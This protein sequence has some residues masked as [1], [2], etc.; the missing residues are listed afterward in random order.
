V[1]GAFKTAATIAAILPMATNIVGAPNLAKQLAS[2]PQLAQ[3]LGNQG[4]VMAGAGVQRQIDD[5]VRLVQ[6]YG[7]NVSDW[8][9]VTSSAYRTSAGQIL[10]I[11][12]Y[13][14]L[15]TG[16]VVEP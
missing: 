3:V 2:E 1:A 10:E 16:Q 15:A 5:I 8:A 13:E 11:H 7:G 6:E 4:K 14:N 9:K 12:A